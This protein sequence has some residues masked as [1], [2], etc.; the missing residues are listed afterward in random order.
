MKSSCA[1]PACKSWPCE[2][3]ARSFVSPHM[4]S[5]R[6]I[7]AAIRLSACICGVVVSL[8]DPIDPM[9]GKP[10]VDNK[11]PNPSLANRPI[12]GLSLFSAMQP[13]AA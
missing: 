2:M 9:T 6:P 8:R 1:T 5:W 4:R 7:S 13:V 3:S 10:Q 12:I 11:N